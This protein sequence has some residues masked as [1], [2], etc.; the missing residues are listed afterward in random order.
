MIDFDELKKQLIIDEGCSYKVYEDSMGYSTIGIGHIV[1]PSDGIPLDAVVTP[2]FVEA[3][4]N[5]DIVQAEDDCEAIFNNWDYLPKRVKHVL[6]NMAFNLGRTRLSKFK[7]M[8]AAVHTCNFRRAAMEMLLSKWY[9]Q[10]GKRAARLA[11]EMFAEGEATV[12]GIF[13]N[14]LHSV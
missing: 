4:Y 1:V 10:T 3:L 5:E 2:V 9:R 13:E 14:K 11:T 6:I 7:R 12:H 8:I